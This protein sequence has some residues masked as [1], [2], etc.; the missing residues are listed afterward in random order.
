M[1]VKCRLCGKKIDKKDA[2]Q[3]PVGGGRF[4]YCNEEEAKIKEEERRKKIE[5][6]LKAKEENKQKRIDP[7]YEE[8]ADIFGY[9]IGN[10]ALFKEMKVWRGIC[11]DKKILAYL[12]ENKDYI[13]NAINRLDTTEYAKIRYFSAILKNSLKDFSAK[14]N[15]KIIEE[16]PVLETA[17]D[18]DYIMPVNRKKKT[19]RRKGFGE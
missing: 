4:Y 10:S 7:V 14:N 13:T 8:V 17:I 3:S 6:E 11:D 9:R 1:Q 19:E 12:K 18:D 16:K 15:T 2:F 5:D